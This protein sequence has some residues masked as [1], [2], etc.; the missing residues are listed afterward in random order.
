MFEKLFRESKGQPVEYRGQRLCLAD[1]FRVSPSDR[2]V[3]QFESA[4]G[5]YRQGVML[6]TKGRFVINDLEIRKAAVLWHDTAPASV[7]VE[8]HSEDGHVLIYNVWDHGNGVTEYWHNGAAMIVDELE[9]GI[10]RYSCNDGYPDDD[11]DDLVFV[12]RRECAG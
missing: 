9:A 2:L 3:V 11:L 7:A 5:R 6:K 12:V 1:K 8:V 10:K 4:T